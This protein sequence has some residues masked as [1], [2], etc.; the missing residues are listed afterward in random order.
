MEKITEGEHRINKT[1]WK[2]AI[3]LGRADLAYLH[4]LGVCR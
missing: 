3:V 1:T 2:V 4:Y